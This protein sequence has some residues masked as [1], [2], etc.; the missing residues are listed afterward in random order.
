MGQMGVEEWKGSAEKDR[1]RFLEDFVDDGGQRLQ[2]GERRDASRSVGSRQ[3]E[4]GEIFMAD[5]KKCAH[6]S[7]K[8]VTTEKYCSE[9]CSD[10]KNMTELQCQ[11]QHPACGETL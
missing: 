3:V 11:C 8:C 1:G 6:P 10:A 2:L 7:C 4:R 5:A 9:Y